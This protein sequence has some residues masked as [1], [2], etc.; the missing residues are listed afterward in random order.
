EDR[1][2]AALEP[3]ET[4]VGR[5]FLGGRVARSE[6]EGQDGGR[7]EATTYGFGDVHGR[8]PSTGVGSCPAA[9]P[10]RGRRDRRRRRLVRCRSRECRRPPPAWPH[11]VRGR[12]GPLRE[13][14]SG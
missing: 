4:V 13:R 7:C 8:I 14:R 9:T 2:V 3:D 11:A 12:T 6:A 10:S 5:H 1:I